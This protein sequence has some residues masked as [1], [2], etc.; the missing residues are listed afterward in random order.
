MPTYHIPGDKAPQFFTPGEESSQPHTEHPQHE[1]YIDDTVQEYEPPPAVEIIEPEK[2]VRF[3]ETN[4]VE[5][6]DD[7]KTNF[8][9]FIILIAIIAFIFFAKRL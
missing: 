9:Y 6:E 7:N 5:S 3:S 1:A 4:E 2:K 8:M